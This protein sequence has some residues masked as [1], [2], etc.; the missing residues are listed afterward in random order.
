MKLLSSRI[1]S[2]R[3]KEQTVNQKQSCNFGE[4]DFEFC[5]LWQFFQGHNKIEAFVEILNVLEELNR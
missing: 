3:A 4:I 5:L 1:R 2:S